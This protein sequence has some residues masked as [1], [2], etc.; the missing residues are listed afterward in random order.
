MST[1][2]FVYIPFLDNIKQETEQMSGCLEKL[3]QMLRTKIKIIPFTF[4]RTVE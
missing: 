2:N 4:L 1:L 3:Q